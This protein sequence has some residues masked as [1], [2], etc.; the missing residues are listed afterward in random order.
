VTADKEQVAQRFSASH[1]SQNEV[2]SQD[3]S[4]QSTWCVYEIANSE[5]VEV[6]VHDATAG[7]WVEPL[8]DRADVWIEHRGT[9]RGAAYSTD[10]AKPRA[11]GG[12][13]LH[14][15]AIGTSHAVDVVVNTSSS[16]RDDAITKASLVAGDALV[17][18]EG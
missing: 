10:S 11:T 16:D 2:T 14:Y 8:K 12:Y 5:S 13:R 15:R 18:L 1:V 7:D 9:G 6:Q 4:T 17:A 3:D